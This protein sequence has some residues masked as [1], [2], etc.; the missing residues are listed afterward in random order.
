MFQKHI[1]YGIGIDVSSKL[2]FPTFYNQDVAFSFSRPKTV[3]DVASQE[4]VV[5]VLQKT[6][7]TNEF[8]HFLFYGPPGTGKTS[9]ILAVA[10]Q[11]FG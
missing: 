10:K 7:T 8:P 11:L 5:S 3:A 2:I 9:T 1:F 4:E 6:I